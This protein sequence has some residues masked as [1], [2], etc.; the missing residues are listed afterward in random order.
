MSVVRAAEVF[1]RP[2]LVQLVD[3]AFLGDLVHLHPDRGGLACAGKCDLRLDIGGVSQLGN[4]LLFQLSQGVTEHAAELAVGVGDPFGAQRDRGDTQR[5]RFEGVPIRSNLN[6][7]DVARIAVN[8]HRFPG[9]DIRARLLRV[10]GVANVAIWGG[11]FCLP[12]ALLAGVPLFFIGRA[13]YRRREK[14]T[15]FKAGNVRDF[16]MNQGRDYDLYLPLD[17]DSLMSGDTIV[18]PDSHDVLER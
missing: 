1:R 11:I 13:V 10:P 3:H 8:G 12:L 14:N 4:G 9:V 18:H 7:T 17:S 2:S 6:Q 5:R 15:A 16:L